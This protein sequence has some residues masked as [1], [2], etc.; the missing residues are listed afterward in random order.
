MRD[1]STRLE[2]AALSMAGPGSIKDRLLDAYRSHLEDVQES[3]LPGALG[4]EFAE[5]IQA[6]HRAPCAAWRRCGQGVGAQALQRGGPALRRTGG[7]AVRHVRRHEAADWQ[8]SAA[9]AWLQPHCSN[10]CRSRRA[11]TP[12]GRSVQFEFDRIPA[13]GFLVPR[14]AFDRIHQRRARPT[15]RSR[16]SARPASSAWAAR[17]RIAAETPPACRWPWRN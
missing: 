16:R 4:P 9:I 6:L 3:D 5:M 11:P 13:R 14:L 12:E 2:A 10:F 15:P 1:L 7:A 17:G 8:A